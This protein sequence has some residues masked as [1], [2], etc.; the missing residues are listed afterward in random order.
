MKEKNNH[1]AMGRGKT[2]VIVVDVQGDF[3][4]FARGTLAVPKTDR[5]FI[6]KLQHGTRILKRVGLP[7]FATQDWHP[8]QHTSFYTNHPG[9]KAFDVTTVRGQEQV[10]WP[11]HCV[12]ETPGARLL[13]DEKLFD[14]VVKKGTEIEFDS[15]SGFRD[16]G[17]HETALHSILQESGI[18][19][20]VIYG[21]ATDYCVK[22]TALDAVDRG[23]Q[24]F[25]V[26][27]LIRGVETDSSKRAL[28]EMAERGIVLLDTLRLESITP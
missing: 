25:V 9:K 7:I 24:V 1:K 20:T 6:E 14:R 17:G 27:N 5:G 21:I 15:Y 23:Y 13:V 4:E 26:K 28:V 19:K 11:P 2:A 16:D 22:A 10:L 8:P 12:Q 3:T 18:S